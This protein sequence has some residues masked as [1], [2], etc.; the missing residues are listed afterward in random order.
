MIV[1]RQSQEVPGTLKITIDE[2][3]V[4][5]EWN[6]PVFWIPEMTVEVSACLQIESDLGFKLE[7][8]ASSLHLEIDDILIHWP[9]F[10]IRPAASQTPSGKAIYRLIEQQLL[11]SESFRKDVVEK[12]LDQ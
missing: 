1:H 2:F 6:T 8:D 5:D 10:N 4:L 12:L 11:A 9:D 7:P 3:V